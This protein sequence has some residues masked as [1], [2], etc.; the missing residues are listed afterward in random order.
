[1]VG[2]WGLGLGGACVC[3]IG[4]VLQMGFHGRTSPTA[5]CCTRT[6]LHLCAGPGRPWQNQVRGPEIHTPSMH[7]HMATVTLCAPEF[8]PSGC[9]LVRW[10]G[11]VS[12]PLPTP[13]S[14]FPTRSMF[15]TPDEV[16]W[17][18]AR[19]ATAPAFSMANVR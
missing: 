1:M 18:N 7:M 19:K 6:H 12:L 10:L 3:V 9:V 13:S 4:R 14:R 5:A 15:G 8:L 17:R 16:H 11:R 2:A